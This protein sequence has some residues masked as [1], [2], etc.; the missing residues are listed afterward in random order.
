MYIVHCAMP[1]VKK[2]YLKVPI[3]KKDDRA[4]PLCIEVIT[5]YARE[6][7]AHTTWEKYPIHGVG[8]KSE[9]TLIKLSGRF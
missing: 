1:R 7:T 6:K 9:N 2:G 8:N 5:L 4:L 3:L